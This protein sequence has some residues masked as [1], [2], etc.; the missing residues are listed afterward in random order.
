MTKEQIAPL[1]QASK[2]LVVAHANRSP[3]SKNLTLGEEDALFNLRWE[4]KKLEEK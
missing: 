3:T 1:V 2:R 4:L